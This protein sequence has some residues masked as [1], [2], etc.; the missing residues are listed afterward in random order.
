VEIGAGAQ[1]AANSL[2]VEDVAPGETVAG[3]PAEPI[4]REG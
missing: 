2:V 1:V 3:V 4:E